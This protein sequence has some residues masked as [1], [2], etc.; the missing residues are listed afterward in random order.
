MRVR[1]RAVFAEALGDAHRWLDE[2]T[3]HT[4]QTTATIAAREAR[5]NVR[6]A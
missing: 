6:S 5:P 1:A 2:L 4:D 3:R